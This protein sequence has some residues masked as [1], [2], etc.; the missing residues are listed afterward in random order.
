MISYATILEHL[1]RAAEEH[2]QLADSIRLH[3][4]LLTLQAQAAPIAAADVQEDA[5]AFAIHSGLPVLA[6]A[7]VTFDAPALAD[8]A[9]TVVGV[10]QR[11]RPDLAAPLSEVD[12]W[13]AGRDS[14]AVEMAHQF[15][16]N[17]RVVAP[18]EA[19]GAADLAAFVLNNTLHPFLRGV[20][21]QLEPAL[22]SAVWY[23]G[24]CPLC[25]G[26]PDMAALA[27]ENGQRRLLCSRCDME[28][29][30]YR[31]ACPYCGNDEH[32][33]YYPGEGA[34]RVY[35]CESCRRYLKTID[36]REASG[37][38]LL[39]V[40]RVLTIEADMAAQSAGWVS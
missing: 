32:M 1:D 24:E 11:H 27:R 6:D 20:A 4:D 29:T 7:D 38:R 15:L 33:S 23:R 30:F 37:E 10:V 35:V 22:A 17:G 2:P 5:V 26:A 3:T 18:A 14:N 28:W 25:Q 34:L 40:E 12:S 36:L 31:T 21:A 16:S 19:S 13:L 8:L 39:P 9:H